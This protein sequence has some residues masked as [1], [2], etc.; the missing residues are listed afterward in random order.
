MRRFP[1]VLANSPYVKDLDGIIK[2]LEHVQI[3][4][5]APEFSLPDTAGVSVSLSDFR[6]NMCYWILGLLASPRVARKTPN[7]VNAFQQ[8][9]DKNFTIVG[10]SLDKDKAKWQKTIADDHLTWALT[11][12]T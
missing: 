7:V 1:P 9:K 5:V 8:Y 10:I 2:Q 11:F 4:Q 3:G 12:P 6:E